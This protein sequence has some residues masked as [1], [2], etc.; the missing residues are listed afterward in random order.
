MGAGS[1][2]DGIAT[3]IAQLEARLT[4][5]CAAQDARRFFHATYLRTT[6]A[7]ADEVGRQGFADS[8]WLERLDVAFADL[9]VQ[10]LAADLLGEPV[11]F[12]WRVAFDTARDRPDLSPV[13][14]VLLG[15]NAHINYDLPQALLAVITPAEFDD[16]AVLASRAADHRRIDQ[17]LMARVAAEDTEISAESRTTA[18]RTTASG[19]TASG[20]TASGTT[21][22][23]TT[24]SGT[25]VVDRLLRPANRAATRRF[26]TEARAKVWSNTAILDSARR[27]GPDRYARVL[28]E[29]ERL[30]AD[31]LGDLTGPGP[32]LLRLAR[33][34]FGV[35][36]PAAVVHPQSGR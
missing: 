35:V 19:T 17:I 5:L 33:R 12:P 25:T 34:G 23:G 7:V 30:C 28:A 4:Q 29:L 11:P 31:R 26:L 13:H 32:V 8:G 27:A 3:V 18:S 10:A 24:A 36:L 15:M 16:R 2:G 9:Y 14:H 1:A 6:R 21:A 20:T 22:S